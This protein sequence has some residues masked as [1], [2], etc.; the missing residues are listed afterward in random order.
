MVG[1]RSM[2]MDSAARSSG[3]N[4]Q[5]PLTMTKF[6]PVSILLSILLIATASSPSKSTN[7]PPCPSEQ[8]GGAQ[9]RAL[10]QFADTTSDD[11]LQTWRQSVGL[12]VVAVSQITLVSDTTVCRRALDAYN[13][14][15]RADSLPVSSTVNVISY[16]TTRYIVGDPL[17]VS[18]G[19]ANE[20]IADTAFAKLAIVAR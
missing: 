19:W 17:H 12:P 2:R 7:P 8:G 10:Y 6:I 16:G 18:H 14:L 9:I 13:V 20:L 15:L 5:A 4:L 11:G 3:P 1:F